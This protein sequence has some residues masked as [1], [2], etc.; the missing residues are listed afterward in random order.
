MH[1]FYLGLYAFTMHNSMHDTS[2]F[3]ACSMHGTYIFLHVPCI[4][5]AY[6]SLRVMHIH[7]D[8]PDYSV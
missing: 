7:V 4:V 2:I 5:R 6:Y 3:H 1:A 8:L